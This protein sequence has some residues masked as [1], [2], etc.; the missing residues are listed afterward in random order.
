MAPLRRIL[1]SFCVCCAL[2][3]AHSV[4]GDANGDGVFDIADMVTILQEL[5]T[6]VAEDRIPALDTN[7]DGFVN[8]AD[9]DYARELLLGE[10][11][12]LPV[13]LEITN[14]PPQNVYTSVS[15]IEII[16][17]V[18][19]P[20]DVT[21]HNIELP[22]QTGQFSRIFYLEEGM[23]II[24]IRALPAGEMFPSTDQSRTVVLDLTPPVVRV[25]GPDPNV[26][27][28]DVTG[29]ISGD[30]VDDSPT[31]V[32][33]TTPAGDF[34]ADVAA[35]GLWEADITLVEGINDITVTAVDAAGLVNSTTTRLRAF[36]SDEATVIS[37]GGGTLELPEGALPNEDMIVRLHDIAHDE[38][39]SI[40]DI[41]LLNGPPP[42]GLTDLPM[43]SIIMPGG[44]VLETENAPPNG[45]ALFQ[46]DV[47][48]GIP[49]ETN[50]DNTMPLWIFQIQ[51]DIDG[52]GEPQLELV[53]RARV[54]DDGSM[55][56]PITDGESEL[57]D[58]LPGFMDPGNTRFEDN[59]LDQV[60]GSRAVQ[61]LQRRLRG[62]IPA[63][64]I[65]AHIATARGNLKLNQKKAPVVPVALNGLDSNI[66]KSSQPEVESN[67][68]GFRLDL[69]NY[70]DGDLLNLLIP[71][72]VTFADELGSETP[73]P[74]DPILPSPLERDDLPD[75]GNPAT[76]PPDGVNGG[77]HLEGTFGPDMASGLMECYTTLYG[78]DVGLN[79]SGVN[80]LQ[81]Q[82]DFKTSEPDV[83]YEVTLEDRNGPGAWVEFAEPE[84]WETITIAVGQFVG[85]NI[86]DLR[87]IRWR[88][89]GDAGQRMHF[90]MDNPRFIGGNNPP[91]PTPTDIIDPTPFP[92][93]PTPTGTSSPTPTPSPTVAPT[94]TAATPEP[95]STDPTPTQI[96]V[97]V[98]P[99]GTAVTPVPP[100][101]DPDDDPQD[102]TQVTFYCCAASAV[103]PYKGKTKCDDDE[104]VNQQKLR[105]CIADA[106]SSWVRC[107][108]RLQKLLN[109][110]D[111]SVESMYAGY[112]ELFGVVTL[113]DGTR[114]PT[115]VGGSLF[116]AIT[117]SGSG[118]AANLTKALLESAAAGLKDGAA[119]ESA[120]ANEDKAGINSALAGLS[121]DSL[122]AFINGYT[123]QLTD[124]NRKALGV[125]SGFEKAWAG[126]NAGAALYKTYGAMKN[127]INGIVFSDALNAEIDF[128]MRQ[129]TDL[130]RRFRDLKNCNKGSNY[131]ARC[132]AD[133]TSDILG[134]KKP[135]AFFAEIER[136]AERIR[137]LREEVEE[138]LGDLQSHVETF[139]AS[140]EILRTTMTQSVDVEENSANV[141]VDE[142]RQAAVDV[143][144]Q[145]QRFWS[146]MYIMLEQSDRLEPAL[147]KAMK[148]TQ[149][150]ELMNEQANAYRQGVEFL[151]Q[152][153]ETLDEGDEGVFVQVG[154]QSGN[155]KTI[156]GPGGSFV[157]YRFTTVPRVEDGVTFAGGTS[158]V[159]AKVEGS[160]LEGAQ[161]V[162]Y[163]EITF[164]FTPFSTIEYDQVVDVGDVSVASPIDDLDGIPPV[165]TLRNPAEP[166][167]LPPGIPFFARGSATD[168]VIVYS[169]RFLIDG[170]PTE[171][172]GS[173]DF[174]GNTAP[175]EFQAFFLVPELEDGRQ[176][177]TFTVQAQAID[178][179]GNIGS[180]A[181]VTLTVDP[182]APTLGTITPASAT[183]FVGGGTVSFTATVT[184][185]GDPMPGPV[186]FVEGL[187]GGN[188]TVG[189]ITPS[190]V[191]TPPMDLPA[192]AF[193]YAIQVV[194]ADDPT[195][196]AEAEVVVTATTIPYSSVSVLN[197]ILPNTQMGVETAPP[198]TVM[199]S[200]LPND[201]AG[202]E[203]A[204]PVSILNL[205]R[206][207]YRAGQETAA[208]VSVDNQAR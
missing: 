82:F 114:V 52:D 31:V 101:D 177:N 93:T 157:S 196:F 167:S 24:N 181:E 179:G 88:A 124:A 202:Q 102:K 189:T 76:A 98:T 94:R 104:T 12:R 105:E 9:V 29:T 23:N 207:S 71:P 79:L 7:E 53:S 125:R 205:F 34:N 159:D 182:D 134:G 147:E 163:P 166:V 108:M 91:N 173:D 175:T 148:G 50:A 42:G 118:K 89:R 59:Q 106:R 15:Q 60:E 129:C 156:S 203:A 188:A 16:G 135:E 143:S 20:A 73:D 51:P 112:D 186:W 2:F 8:E 57:D 58:A 168:D 97:T 70:E 77:V 66:Y 111:G 17:T 170:L 160:I 146:N 21:L 206:P 32:T 87:R 22:S 164:P 197:Q 195:L 201:R 152:Q 122:N 141:S 193:S 74:N 176:F 49:N 67:R 155:T 115:V 81:F 172:V 46:R 96:P 44:L 90:Q 144:I 136:R 180:S 137:T 83:I 107:E 37:P 150:A 36:L 113:P 162:T 187:Q 190:G 154:G 64:K 204:A 41:T 65:G 11:E 165:V 18:N 153:V 19:E 169:S 99:T 192:L 78:R 35:D 38:L 47:K 171:A 68:Q 133:G 55:I 92:E 194:S 63:P 121:Q 75:E 191:Y 200:F 13:D 185:S 100:P 40:L 138:G 199:G 4:A 158:D 30:L 54:S 149:M 109:E 80:N 103:I 145:L 56:V 25:T 61:D 161:S 14:P 72:G 39:Q 28:S 95:T 132:N 5:E 110:L 128:E 174:V 198:V 127:M 45:Q 117:V 131:W 123:S 126:V 151:G 33:V 139:H 43:N 69:D 86:A 142:H 84:D 26:A 184:S 62:E 48:I 1:P 27:W 6:G 120:I 10:R 85:V 119:L 3:P 178:V 116:Q 208:P 140:V 183:T 130:Y